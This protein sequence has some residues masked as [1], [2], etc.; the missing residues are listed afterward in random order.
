MLW[1]RASNLTYRI[2]HVQ[3]FSEDI[4]FCCKDRPQ[5]G[6][7]RSLNTS[8]SVLDIVLCVSTITSIQICKSIL[9]LTLRM[10][11]VSTCSDVLFPS[12]LFFRTLVRYPSF[13]Y[14][15]IR[16][17]GKQSVDLC[18]SGV[19]RLRESVVAPSW[20]V[21]ED[22]RDFLGYILILLLL[23]SLVSSWLWLYWF[24]IF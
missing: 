18:A 20:S 8:Q 22:S 13:L 7:L 24:V 19:G 23:T 3:Y 11:R 1:L 6:K 15:R 10:R 4:L 16:G 2:W 12:P 9:A 5:L 17:I 14:N 21:S